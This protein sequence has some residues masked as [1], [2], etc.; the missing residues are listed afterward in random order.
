[1]YH[2][3]ICTTSKVHV[4]TLLYLTYL[5]YQDN[6]HCLSLDIN[7]IDIIYTCILRIM[8]VLYIYVYKVIYLLPFLCF[9]KSTL[10]S[11]TI[12]RVRIIPLIMKTTCLRYRN[13]N[14]WY[15]V[16]KCHYCLDVFRTKM[17]KHYSKFSTSKNVS[18]EN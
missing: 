6:H 14:A 16:L 15:M 9:R 10:N 13:I 3:Y 12:T 11:P 2:I 7:H 17:G 8:Y 18:L 4:Y 5:H 1:M